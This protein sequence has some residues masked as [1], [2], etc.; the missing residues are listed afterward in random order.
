MI[1][2]MAAKVIRKLVTTTPCMAFWSGGQK[3][4]LIEAIIARDQGWLAP[5]IWPESE[6][7]NV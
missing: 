5:E 2:V 4:H 6:D 3:G 1:A 7:E